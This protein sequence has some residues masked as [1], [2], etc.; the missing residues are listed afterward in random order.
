MSK[1]YI[2]MRQSSAR[3]TDSVAADIM[4][5]LNARQHLGKALIVANEPL[6]T[7]AAARKQWLKLARALQ[8]QR[9][10]T[11]NADK[12]LKFTHSIA[13]MQNAQFTT[14]S[15]LETTDAEIYFLAPDNLATIPVQCWTI[16][17]LAEPTIDVAKNMITQ[18]PA[19]TLFVDYAQTSDWEKLGLQPKS[20]LEDQVDAEWNQVQQFLTTN[21]IDISKLEDDG[22]LE[23]DAMDDALDILLGANRKFLQVANEFQRTLELARPLRIS[24][25]IRAHQDSLMLLAHRVQAL[26]PGVFTQHFLET[27]NEDDTFFLHDVLRSCDDNIDLS[28]IFARHIAAGRNRLAHALL[29]T[30]SRRASTAFHSRPAYFAL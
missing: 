9:A 19:E 28:E 20:V 2:E 13:R 21:G 11:L 29:Q 5:H 7:L 3:G 22:V 15:P 30:N 8:R 17:L 26:S 18:L 12:I 6:G 25:T 27:F 14:K 23:V 1:C 16:Y 24:K 10:Q 4:R